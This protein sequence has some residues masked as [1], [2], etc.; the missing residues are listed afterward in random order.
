MEKATWL[1]PHDVPLLRCDTCQEWVHD[2]TENSEGDE[3][4]CGGDPDECPSCEGR[5]GW[6]LER[7]DCIVCHGATTVP[8]KG[9]LREAWG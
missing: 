6:N 3:H 4:Q 1:Y 9:V 2:L 7:D 5:G 8:V